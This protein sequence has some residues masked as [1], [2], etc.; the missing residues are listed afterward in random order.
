MSSQSPPPPNSKPPKHNK[1][2]TYFI[3]LLLGAGT[4]FP[5]NAFITVNQYYS[6]RFC[7]SPYAGDY[8]AYYGFVFNLFEV[9]TL[10]GC[11][12]YGWDTVRAPLYAFVVLFMVTAASVFVSSATPASVF[13]FTLCELGLVGILTALLSGGVFGLGAGFPP[14]Y[15]QAIMSGQGLAGTVVSI[16]EIGTQLA[17]GKDAR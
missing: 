10:I 6:S 2:L 14:E 4:L 3:F 13:F 7:G 1:V 12:M 16:S 15:T 9:A 5:W 8:L 11:V 17:G